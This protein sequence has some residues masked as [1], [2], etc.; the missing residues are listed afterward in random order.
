PTVAEAL[1]RLRRLQLAAGELA[2][3]LGV[4]ERHHV[5]AV[6][7]EAAEEQVMAVDVESA[8]VDAAHR[9]P[10]DVTRSQGGA[11]EARPHEGCSLELLVSGMDGHFWILVVDGD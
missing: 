4:H 8:R 6:H 3:E 9:H 5:D 7:D 2:V 1:G 11:L 10:A